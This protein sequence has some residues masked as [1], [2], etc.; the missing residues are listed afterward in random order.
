VRAIEALLPHDFG[1]L[2]ATTAFGKTIA[3]LRMMAECRRNTL[4]LVHRRQLSDNQA[5]DNYIG[6]SMTYEFAVLLR[7]A[8]QISII[9]NKTANP[10]TAPAPSTFASFRQ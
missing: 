3:A 6:I 9:Q 7:M 8:R 1:V 2:S 10:A 4:D 5:V